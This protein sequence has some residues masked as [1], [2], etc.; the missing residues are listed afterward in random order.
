MKAKLF[1]LLAIVSIAVSS[2]YDDSALIGR[3]ED[4]EQRIQNLETLCSQMNTNISSLQDLLQAMQD[5]DYITSVTPV[6]EGDK[7]IG[8]VINFAK[9]A[10][11]TIYHGQ[12][13]KDGADGAAGVDGAVGADGHTPAFLQKPDP[14]AMLPHSRRQSG[15]DLPY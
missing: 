6:N 15:T 8:Y 2:C 10:P 11:V 13:G 9:A 3:I 1:A 14:G 7:V 12:D 4:H 5:Q